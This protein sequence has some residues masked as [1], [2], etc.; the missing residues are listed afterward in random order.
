MEQYFSK[1]SYRRGLLILLPL[2]ALYAFW[3]LGAH[4]YFV[5]DE[6]RG[7]INALEMLANGDWVNLHYSGAPD[8]VRSKPPMLIWA[9]S[10]SMTLFGKTAFALRFPSAV[11]IVVA[12]FFVYRIVCLYCR[13]IFALLVGL[14]L[15]SVRGMVG[16]HV[17]RTGDF[18]ALLL[19]FLMAGVF[20]LLRYL[21][22]DRPRAIYAAGLSWGLAF[23]VKGPAMGALLPGIVLYLLL[24][25][26]FRSTLQRKSFWGGLAILLLFPVFWFTTVQLYGVQW[27][28][29][30]Y[31]GSNVFERLFVH[32]LYERFTQTDFEGRRDTSGYDFILYSLD[33]MFNLWNYAFFGFLLYGL[34]R[35]IRNR[36]GVWRWITAPERR[37]LLLSLCLWFPYAVF[38]SLITQ[39]LR[40]YIVPAL[41]FVAIVTVWGVVWLGNRFSWTH[42][43]FAGLLLF[44]LGRRFYEISTPRPEPV[45]VQYL[46]K[47]AGASRVFIEADALANDELYYVYLSNQGALHFDSTDL[48]GP[49]DY[50][51]L[52]DSSWRYEEFSEMKLMGKTRVG[53]LFGQAQ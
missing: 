14:V 1:L 29:P 20:F 16:W 18:D 10:G 39:A 49:F 44:T 48:R 40:Q 13:P 12:M 35:F 23:L 3:M 2:T 25:E 28:N 36:T 47:I 45:V 24:T 34:Y 5:G 7:G 4:P 52:R 15:L 19:M 11:A 32:D 8:A 22:H 31:T 50:V 17:G 30:E 43:L 33:K 21:D 42:Y 46:P 27:E 26:R 37:L 53:K 41:P 38:L 51:V 9:I 6:S